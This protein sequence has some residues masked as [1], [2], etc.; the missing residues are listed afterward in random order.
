[1]NELV[2]EIKKLNGYI[3]GVGNLSDKIL[4]E[5][6][7]ND[8]I[9]VNLLTNDNIKL[10]VNTK[11]SN[12]KKKNGKSIKISKLKKYFKT[13]RPDYIICNVND[14]KDYLKH[15]IKDSLYITNEKIYIYTE[16]NEIDL[17]VI[18]KRYRRYNVDVVKGKKNIVVDSSNYKSNIFKNIYYYIVDSFINLY[19][20]ISTILTS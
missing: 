10:P 7:K 17:D 4:K 5:F 8:F 14:V 3:L 19:D 15:F 12:I 11:F 1:M 6:L 20:Y 18:F 9:E 13:K 2:Y 16:N